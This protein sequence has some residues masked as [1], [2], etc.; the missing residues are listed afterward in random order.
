MTGINYLLPN[1][2]QTQHTAFSGAHALSLAPPPPPPPPQL[3]RRPPPPAHHVLAPNRA[4]SS[5]FFG[6]DFDLVYNYFKTTVWALEGGQ[7]KVSLKKI[8]N[9][10]VCLMESVGIRMQGLANA[11][12]CLENNKRCDAQGDVL[13]GDVGSCEVDRSFTA[14]HGTDR[15]RRPWPPSAGELPATQYP[16]PI[17]ELA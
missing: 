17:S 6:W 13:Q 5:V 12:G 2:Y 7:G 14:F 8:I 1:G 16:F 15:P 4:E 9:G 11:L 10:K 3:N